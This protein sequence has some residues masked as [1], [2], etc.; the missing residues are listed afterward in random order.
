MGGSREANLRASRS[1]LEDGSLMF[2][3]LLVTESHCVSNAES[4]NVTEMVEFAPAEEDARI[5]YLRGGD[6]ESRHGTMIND[7]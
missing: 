3:A 2:S 4:Q 6:E 5:V 1:N 7:E